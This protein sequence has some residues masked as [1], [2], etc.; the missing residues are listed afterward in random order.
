MSKCLFNKV[1]TPS[2]LGEAPSLPDVGV[3][4]YTILFGRFGSNAKVLSK[5]RYSDPWGVVPALFNP[6]P[7]LIIV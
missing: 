7:S 3:A 6:N 1:L 4:S 5:V 2:D